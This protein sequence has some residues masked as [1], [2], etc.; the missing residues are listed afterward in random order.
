[1]K[2]VWFIE[3]M[4]PMRTCSSVL[5]LPTPMLANNCTKRTPTRYVFAQY[6]DVLRLT[7]QSSRA[8][9]VDAFGSRLRTAVESAWATPKNGAGFYKRVDLSAV[10][11]GWLGDERDRVMWTETQAWAL[12]ADADPSRIPALVDELDRAVRRPSPVGALN[13][14]RY[15]G[16]GDYAGVWWCGNM[17]LVAGLARHGYE[18][19]T[20]ICK[21]RLDCKHCSLLHPHTSLVRI[22]H[23]MPPTRARRAIRL[24]HR[25]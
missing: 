9:E 8:T 7:G 16:A 14:G 18:A 23:M 2:A 12:L 17:A 5:T 6:A 19:Q 24:V 1:M 21:Q 11:G 20:T 3:S 25:A 13:T 22:Q 4:S 10:N 15:E